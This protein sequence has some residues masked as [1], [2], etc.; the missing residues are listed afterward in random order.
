MKH[1]ETQAEIIA[2]SVRAIGPGAT[3]AMLRVTGAATRVQCPSLVPSGHL[4][5]QSFD[6]AA[7]LRQHE[8]NV[9]HWVPAERDF[10]VTITQRETGGITTASVNARN[11]L[12]ALDKVQAALP[13]G[14]DAT[15]A[16]RP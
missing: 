8:A 5:G 14:F 15:S 7:E 12:L 1:P 3:A 2:E 11:G 13:A 4:C 10:V 9:I 6:S 16:R